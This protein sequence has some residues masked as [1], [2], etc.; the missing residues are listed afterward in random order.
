MASKFEAGQKAFYIS[1]RH[2]IPCNVVN[3]RNKWVEVECLTCSHSCHVWFEDLYPTRAEAEAKLR[4]M[5]DAP[6]ER[7]EEE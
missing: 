1:S 4:E 3:D 6:A 2:I 5:K 7:G